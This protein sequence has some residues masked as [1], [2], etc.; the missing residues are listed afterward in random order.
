MGD[1]EARA[2]GGLICLGEVVPAPISAGPRVL[3]VL[4]IGCATLS[5]ADGSTAG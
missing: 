5:Q 1:G 4:T 3:A 2:V